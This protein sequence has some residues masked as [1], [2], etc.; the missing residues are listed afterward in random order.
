[1]TLFRHV[2]V[3]C[4]GGAQDRSLAELAC[5]LVGQEGTLS[6]LGLLEPPE[7]LSVGDVEAE[8]AAERERLEANLAALA[9][10]LPAARLPQVT[11]VVGRRYLEIV[12]AA[13]RLGADL[14][15]KTTDPSPRPPIPLF[16]SI[17]QHLLRKCPCPVW[18]LRDAAAAPVAVV[19]AVDLPDDGGDNGALDGLNRE[20]L[21]TAAGIAALGGRPLRLLHAWSDPLAA[22]VRQWAGG[23]VEARVADSTRT[24]EAQAQA[25]LQALI[26]AAEDWLAGEG[27]SGVRL[28][29]HLVAGSAREA[30]PR[31][32]EELGAELLVIGTLARS[33]VAG[34]IIGNTAEDVLNAVDCAVVAVKP[35][36]YVS[37]L[38]R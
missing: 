36:G 14:V 34:V 30:L 2:L 15:M 27:L 13:H 33:G 17:D 3:I 10:D 19:A 5:S 21:R 37:P 11:V 28:L 24:A 20:I 16:A 29:P 8:T 18:L 35:P 6:L 22:V 9:A 4:R 7:G 31:A 25:K 12:R 38:L 1:M 32:V 26:A 23:E